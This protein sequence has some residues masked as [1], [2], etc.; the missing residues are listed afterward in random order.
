MCVQGWSFTDNQ[1]IV[2]LQS[3]HT[4][5]TPTRPP[6]PPCLSVRVCVSSW[7]ETRF[8]LSTWRAAEFL[9]RCKKHQNSGYWTHAMTGY[10]SY[11]CHVGFICW[12]HIGGSPMTDVLRNPNQ[13]SYKLYHED[14][15]IV[16]FYPSFFPLAANITTP[17]SCT[18]LTGGEN[19]N[20]HGGDLFLSNC[21][22]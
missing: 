4:Q 19:L 9:L 22:V 5:L 1:N 17:G 2:S 8:E 14:L 11:C 20:V 21:G 7:V 15:L 16:T 10:L 3:L 12:R 18:L 6:P 13:F